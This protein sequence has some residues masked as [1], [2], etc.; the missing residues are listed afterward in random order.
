[1]G[2]TLAVVGAYVLAGEIVQALAS[3]KDDK[4]ASALSKYEEILKPYVDNAQGLA[5]GVP[6][7]INPATAWGIW[8]MHGLL[9]FMAWTGLD[10]LFMKLAAG[11]SKEAFEFSQYEELNI[12][13]EKSS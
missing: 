13:T 10:R 2:T 5:P 1:M 9:G 11:T 6:H 3:D 7:I 8:I 4:I 12:P